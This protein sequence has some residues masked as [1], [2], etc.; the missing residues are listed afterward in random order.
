[1]AGSA[2]VRRFGRESGIELVLRTRREL[3][4]TSQAAVEAFYTKEKPDAAIIAAGRVGGIQANNTRPAEFI[5][6]NL[7]IAANTIHGAYRHGVK[8]LLFL[9]SSC[10]YPKNAP[11]P[12]PEGALLA[13]PLEPTNEA[14]AVAKIA[15]MKLCQAYRRQYGVVYH[16]AMPTNLYGPGDNYHLLN[17]HVLPALIRKFHEAKESG[18]AEVVAWGTGAP[19]REFMHVD[20]LADA[21]AFLFKLPDPPDWVNVGTGSDVTIKDLTA[22]VA[23]T[24][25]FAGRVTWDASKPDG[26]PRKLLDMRKLTALGWRTRIALAEGLAQ[27]YASF[28]AEKKSGALRQ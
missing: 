13:G 3:D 1:M 15:G 21:C 17:S 27:T 5:F 24:T 8:R 20:D 7:E 28:L 14:Y 2:L 23:T 19:R 22:L 9:G 25:G 11:Q 6:D 12:M 10:I 16:S 26:M 18:S 4:L